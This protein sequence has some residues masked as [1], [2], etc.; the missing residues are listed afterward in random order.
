M[1]RP[2]E[3]HLKTRAFATKDAHHQQSSAFHNLIAEGE[4]LPNTQTSLKMSEIWT[5]SKLACTESLG[6][7]KVMTIS[8][9][10]SYE[11]TS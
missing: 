3:G 10:N 6:K 11:Q 2:L 8:P 9:F 7:T 1:Y 4:W 5:L